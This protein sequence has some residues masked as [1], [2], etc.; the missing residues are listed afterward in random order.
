MTIDQQIANECVQRYLNYLERTHLPKPNFK[1]VRTEL[2]KTMEY[3]VRE[4]EKAIRL[5]HK[6]RLLGI[7]V[8]AGVLSE[9]LQDKDP[10]ILFSLSEIVESLSTIFG[11]RRTEAKKYTFSKPVERCIETVRSKIDEIRSKYESIRGPGYAKYTVNSYILTALNHIEI[12]KR[13]ESYSL[14]AKSLIRLCNMPHER[15]R[16]QYVDHYYVFPKPAIFK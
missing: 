7:G 13:R 6:L 1:Q 4:S 12:I 14:S 15:Q 2:L 10:L 16:Q 8:A 11:E 5:K 3:Y 9:K